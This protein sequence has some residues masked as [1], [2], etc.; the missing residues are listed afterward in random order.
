VTFDIVLGP[1]NESISQEGIVLGRAKGVPTILLNAMP[2]SFLDQLAKADRLS[3]G[4][5]G[6][7]LASLTLPET[8]KAIDTLRECNNGVLR[9]WGV[10]AAAF[11]ALQ[12]APMPI[13]SAADWFTS[14]DYPTA[15]IR[16]GG[17]GTSVVRLTI[18]SSGELLACEPVSKSGHELLDR[19][20][21]NL[22]RKRGRYEP[23]IGADGKPTQAMLIESVSWVMF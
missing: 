1:S 16:K 10:D 11:A 20:T 4:E 14:E 6:R 13:G 2:D 21:C 19:T 5:K 3:I 17:A 9:Q 7:V 23:A 15:I 22:L 12:R 8:Q 18:G